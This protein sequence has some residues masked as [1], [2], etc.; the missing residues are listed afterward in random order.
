MERE[1]QKLLSAIWTGDDNREIQNASV[2][3]EGKPELP[4]YEDV[5][6]V[7]KFMKSKKEPGAAGH[8]RKYI[9]F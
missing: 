4:T 7:I 6:I 1:L 9:T 3:T 2:Q 8:Q 5:R